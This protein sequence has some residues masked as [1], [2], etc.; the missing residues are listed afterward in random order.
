MK[1]NI[2][3]ALA[4]LISSAGLVKA[5]LLNEGFEDEVF[6]PQGWTI[7]PTTT[8]GVINHW[9]RKISKGD[10]E[11]G[12]KA[13]IEITSNKEPA[14]EELIVTPEMQLPSDEDYGLQF[15]WWAQKIGFDANQ[16][17]FMIK[18]QEKGSSEW[19]TLWGIKNKEQVEASGVIFPWMQWTV[20]SPCINLSEWKGKTVK[21]AF[22]YTSIE[23]ATLGWIKIDDIVV[24]KYAA[25]MPEVSGST[26]YIFENV[27]IGVKKQGVLT[28]KN[29]GKDVLKVTGISGLDGTDFSTSLTTEKDKI[30]LRTNEEAKYYVFYNPTA[31]GAGTATLTIETNGGKLNVALSG[32]KTM[33]PEGYTLESFESSMPPLGWTNT[34][35]RLSTSIVISGDHSAASGVL[36]QCTLTSPRLDLSAGNHKVIFDF[37]EDI[38]DETGTTIPEN[39]FTLELKEGDKDWKE[40]WLAKDLIFQ[41]IIRVS[42]DLKSTSNN[43]YLRWRYTGDFSMGFETVLS[44]IYFD[45]IVLP[46]LY[47][48]SA[49]LPASNPVPANGSQNIDYTGITLT[50]EGALFAEGYK[51]Y[52]GTEENNP[53]S[54]VNGEILTGTS[55]STGVLTPGTTYYWKV[56]PFNAA[57]EAADVPVWNFATMPDQTITNF[58]YIMNFDECTTAIPLGWQ[59][60]GDGKG[61][62]TNEYYPFE[63]KN[64]C[65]V[66][67]NTSNKGEA[68]L[69]T[70]LIQLPEERFVTSFWWAKNMPIRLKKQAEGDQPNGQDKGND[71]LTFE[72]KEANGEWTELARTFEEE[73]WVNTIISLE[74]YSGKQVWLRWKYAAENGYEAD[75]G[76]ALDNFY[77]GEETGLN[78]QNIGGN[79]LTIYPTVTKEIIYL[80]GISPEMQAT[81][82][83]IA[84]NVVRKVTN[85][86]RINIASL[87]KGMYILNIQQDN[88]SYTTRIIIKK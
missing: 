71:I 80:H 64:S 88:Q 50:W 47:K 49:L 7:I 11:L 61:W 38:I 86:D 32:T 45:D 43:C 31:T 12:G 42:V 78:I 16:C 35:W 10:N 56:V 54:L 69:Q 20:Y 66:F 24:N 74:Q 22:C 8:D 58:P 63:G 2:L 79:R 34:G 9:E 33:L 40:I 72:I 37:I 27:Y 81:L 51:L 53:T 85:T 75:A 84:G 19:K 30:A 36:E 5:Q 14:K 23:K 70:P 62:N 3:L 68:I 25:P 83:D 18:V 76:G 73:F 52:V 59:I 21:F 57:G 60:Y 44:D 1:K 29:S 4:L 28:L 13:W 67:I 6:P 82:Y 65:S 46:P 77:I 41:E 87:L 17:D 48:E 15:K 55:Y 39:Y 26:S